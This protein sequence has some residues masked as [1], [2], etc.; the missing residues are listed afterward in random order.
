M[1][2][3]WAL[4]N[5]ILQDNVINF[6]FPCKPKLF[7]HRVGRVARAGRTGTAFSLVSGD[8]VILMYI[9]T[10]ICDIRLHLLGWHLYIFIN[11]IMYHMNSFPHATMC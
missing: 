5:L 4:L 1:Q 8:E 6:N 2:K 3:R 9:L 10:T 11:I 7:V